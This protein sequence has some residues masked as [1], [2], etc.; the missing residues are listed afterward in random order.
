MRMMQR[1]STSPKAK[2]KVKQY[3]GKRRKTEQKLD[4]KTMMKDLT[5]LR[6]DGGSPEGGVNKETYNYKL[7][8]KVKKKTQKRT[9]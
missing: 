5:S 1:M 9:M 3:L 4:K 8:K 2:K 7:L 6:S